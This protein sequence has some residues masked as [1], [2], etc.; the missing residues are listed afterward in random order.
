MRPIPTHRSL[1]M[2]VGMLACVAVSGTPAAASPILNPGDFA[3]GFTVT[4]IGWAAFVQPTGDTPPLSGY[5]LDIEIVPLPGSTG[6]VT[7]DPIETSFFDSRN[8][9][10]AAGFERDP[11]RSGLIYEPTLLNP[12][13]V[14]AF[15][16][17][18]GDIP[19]SIVPG[20]NDV[21]LDLHL[22]RS[23]D[24]LGD[25]EIRFG[26]ATEFY[27]V[28]GMPVP[29]DAQS[30]ILHVVPAPATVVAGAWVLALGHRRRTSC[31]RDGHAAS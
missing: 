16:R 15:A 8:V 20:L 12:E 4:G 13:R 30:A 5:T 3:N 27:G 6:A 18:F 9:F 29:F 10:T 23:P 1:A 25:F 31:C 2:A 11:M 21:F 19:V 26:P 7:V 22:L 14:L 28:G 17:T 24:A